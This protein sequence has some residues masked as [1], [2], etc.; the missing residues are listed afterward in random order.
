M[1]ILQ[2]WNHLLQIKCQEIIHGWFDKDQQK[3]LLFRWTR[4]FNHAIF[5]SLYFQ[6]FLEV[7]TWRDLV[8]NT[9]FEVAENKFW[10]NLP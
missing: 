4:L 5:D 9:S 8:A 10:D 1:N 7:L 3:K 2:D 6:V